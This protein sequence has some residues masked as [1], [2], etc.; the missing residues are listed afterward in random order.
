MPQYA[1]DLSG[2]PIL[3]VFAHPDDEGFGC[4]GTLAMLVARGAH[5]TL[6]CA[7]N[8]DVGE[9]SDPS[10]A[11]PETL[12][13][14][15]Q[16]ELRQAMA[17]TGVQDARFLGYR[18][19]GMAGTPDNDHPDSLAQGDPSEVVGRLVRIIREV[20][21]EAVITH[22][23]SG[24]YGHPD[25]LAVHQHVARA[26]PL[27]GDP[28]AYPEQLSQEPVPVGATLS[29][30]PAQGLQPWTPRLLYY[31][32]APRSFF[33]RMWQQMLDAGITPP[34]ASKEIDSLG[35]PDEEV[36]T[37]LDV[38]QFVDTKIASLKCHR[39]QIDPKSPF[40]QLSLA[41]LHDFMSTEYYIL[42]I[43]QGADP[44]ADLLASL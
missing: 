12:A 37:V 18:D 40:Y 26:F 2:T 39:T 22:D 31:A 23:P 30:R 41:A 5:V 9:I 28:A 3:A 38:S 27:A 21:P 15:R 17:V 4:G 11:T 1:K 7:T 14:V 6:V 19:S 36:T 34:F 44:E 13:Q 16:E 32:C 20:R 33:R 42:A 10:L 8:G 25:H 43:P 29:G 24:V 35:S